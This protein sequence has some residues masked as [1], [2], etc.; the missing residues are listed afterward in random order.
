MNNMKLLFPV[1]ALCLISI[2]PAFAELNLSNAKITSADDKLILQFTDNTLQVLRTHTS[3]IPHI[4]YGIV[5]LGNVELQIDD[6]KVNVLGDSFTVKNDYL[7]LYAK[8]LG[9]GKFSINT[10]INTNTGLQKNTF[11][12]NISSQIE[13]ESI[14]T[15]S[16][17]VVTEEKTEIHYLLDQYDRVYNKAEYKFFVKTFDKAVYSG[18]NF[19]SFEGKLDDV[20]VSAI[21]FDPNGELKTEISGFSENGIFEGSVMVPENL[22]QKGWYT[23]DMVIEYDEKF[24]HEQLTFYVYGQVQP[25]GDLSCPEGKIKINNE[26]VD[27]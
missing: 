1:F 16:N 24:H 5:D 19:Q 13:P 3:I 27:V 12:A 11:T 22:W 25:S 20:K 2:T 26:C 8:S 7:A 21:I 23:V 9:D 15:P 18:N 17:P 10:Y 14:I 4:E 6:A